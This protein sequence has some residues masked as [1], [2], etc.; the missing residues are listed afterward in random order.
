M[1]TQLK[2]GILELIILKHL[3]DKDCY[4]Y[5]LNKIINK[6]IEIN[7]STSYAILKKMINKGYCDFYMSE[8]DG[9]YPSRKYYKITDFGKL[10]LIKNIEI[11]NEFQANIN[12]LLK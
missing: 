2:K 10:E 4:A 3:R 7:E 12:E 1:D 11:W 9:N 5:E 6:V 8:S